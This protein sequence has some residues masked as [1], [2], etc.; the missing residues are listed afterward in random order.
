VQEIQ[1]NITHLTSEA[2]KSLKEWMEFRASYGENITGDI[3]QIMGYARY[4][5]DN[6]HY[7]WSQFGTCH[8]S[9]EA[10]VYFSRECIPV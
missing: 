4:M 2:Y 7:L 3:W 1:R 8:M 6:E 9:K 10:Q 5:A